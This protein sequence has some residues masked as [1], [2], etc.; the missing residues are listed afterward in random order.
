M[1]SLFP[2]QFADAQKANVDATY[3][4][5]TE[6]FGTFEKLVKLNLQ[7]M[8][9]SLDVQAAR[10]QSALSG[11]GAQALFDAPQG[12]QTLAE[13]VAAYN[14]QVFD[15]L[16]NAQA[17]LA[18]LAGAQY[19]RQARK[20]QTGVDQAAKSGPVGSEAA[21]AALNSMIHATN[22]WYDSLY[23]TARQAVETAESNMNVVAE[24]AKRTQSGTP[25]ATSGRK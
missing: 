25:H 2:E 3:R 14:R 17:E 20:V 8:K 4:F 10:W 5:A 19:E 1:T 24:A 9:T 11:N 18:Q 23:K 21:V 12:A 15:I 16:M 13:R 7:T 6:V 22:S